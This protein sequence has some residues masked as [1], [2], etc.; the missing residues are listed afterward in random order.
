MKGE[1]L[2]EGA[3]SKISKAIPVKAIGKTQ[4]PI[5]LWSKNLKWS[6]P[7]KTLLK[8]VNRVSGCL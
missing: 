5:N 3:I 2:L 7:L 8:E 4:I 6:W 1:V